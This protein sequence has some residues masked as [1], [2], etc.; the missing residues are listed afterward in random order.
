MAKNIGGNGG[1]LGMGI[2]WSFVGID[3]ILETYHIGKRK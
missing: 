2:S 1:A 3:A